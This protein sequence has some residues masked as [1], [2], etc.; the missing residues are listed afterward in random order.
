LFALHFHMVV[1]NEGSQD[2]T[3]DKA[4]IWRQE[5]VQRPWRGAA[6]WLVLNGLLSQLSYRTQGHQGQGWP[7]PQWAVSAPHHSL[8][9]KVPYRHVYSL[10][11]QKR[12]FSS[13]T[14]SSLVTI[15]CIK[16]I[17]TKT[18]KPLK[19]WPGQLNPCHLDTQIHH[20]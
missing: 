18:N 9:E 5:L 7:H 13:K 20:Y 8:L 14:P 12:A 11:L 1:I 17:K 4:G 2:R 16:L 19:D 10:I 15:S 6:Y 3:P